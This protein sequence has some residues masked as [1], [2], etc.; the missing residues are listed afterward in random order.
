ML[1][2]S[3]RP[4]SNDAASIVLSEANYGGLPTNYWPLDEAAGTSAL[5][6]M[7]TAKGSGN[8]GTAGGTPTRGT[9]GPFRGTRS[10]TFNG[11]TDFFSFPNSS[12]YNS[13]SGS[14][15]AW[16][17]TTMNNYGNIS[18]RDDV[19]SNRAWLFRVEP[20]GHFETLLIFGGIP[21]V[22]SGFAVN[23]GKWHHAAMTWAYDGSSTTLLSQYVDGA[24][25]GTAS[26]SGSMPALNTSL[27]IG[28]VF[29]GAESFA[30][31]VAQKCFYAYAM[32]AAR[33]KAQY[34]S[35]FTG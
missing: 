13:A 31:S 18:R 24:L 3:A 10:T 29:T 1:V 14:I 21:D 17:N 12:A 19:A 28:R 16:F 35:G 20:G 32:S 4:S 34:L 15:L 27:Y 11:S 2:H 33:I 30:G 5:D 6:V 23:D 26:T 22:D 25:T 9:T 7:T 8:A